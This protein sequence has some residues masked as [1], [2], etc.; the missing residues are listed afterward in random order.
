LSSEDFWFWAL[1]LGVAVLGGGALALRW[2]QIA[3]LIEDTPTS[4]L[5]SAA[6]GYVELEGRGLPLEGTKNLAPLT[7]RP[8]VWWNYRVSKRQQRSSGRGDSWHTVA[9]GR[10][11]QPFLLDDGTGRCLV[12]PDGAEVI[13]SES[14]TWYGDTPWPGP[15]GG[16]VSGSRERDYRYFEERIYEQERV[17]A[18][19]EF[20][21]LGSGDGTDAQAAVA[22][23][24]AQWKSDQAALVQRFDTDGDGRISLEEWSRARD[25]ARRTVLEQARDRPPVAALDVLSKPGSGQLFLLAAL[26]AGDL[27]RRYRRKAVVAF[28]AFVAAVYA[29]G[30]LLQGAFRGTPLE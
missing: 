18:L 23:L 13:A 1:T 28:V 24:L 12:K 3:R 9:S 8:C 30:W 11:A 22:A 16:V 2:L 25:E 10:S 26:P 14:T 5:R 15:I 21:T 27:A 29:F 7:Q 6:Q 20:G 4:R 17:Y 19:G